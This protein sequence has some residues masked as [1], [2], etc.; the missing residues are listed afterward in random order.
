MSITEIENNIEKQEELAKELYQLTKSRTTKK[1]KKQVEVLKKQI[2]H[3]NNSLPHLINEI[4]ILQE[5]K[6]PKNLVKVSYDRKKKR[7]TVV[8]HKKDHKKY[9]RN[10]K[11]EK[12]LQ[13]KDDNFRKPS[14][15]AKISSK[16][17]FEVSNKISKNKIF[18]KLNLD[19]RKAN[20]RFLLNTYISIMLFFTLISFFAACIL[21]AILLFYKFSVFF[22]FFV[23]TDESILLRAGKSFW[24][25]FVIPITTFLLFYIY[26]GSEAKSIGKKIDQEL[27]FVTI[28]MSA[29]A[30]SN[31]EP[32]SIFQI[33]VKA[34]KEYPYTSSEFKKII[35]YTSIYGYDLVTALKN[36][37]KTTPSDNLKDLLDG[38][39]NAI[40]TGTRITTFLDKRSESLL[41]NYKLE[42]ERYTKVAETFMNIYISAVIAA[43]LVL[44]LTFFL[45]SLGGLGIGLGLNTIS[46]LIVLVVVLINIGFLTFLHFKQPK[47]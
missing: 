38:L 5:K 34:G 7:D 31:I 35:N 45:M 2:R 6:K 40:S 37:S 14:V 3:I 41:F 25:I 8:L 17:F 24:V 1:N 13:K 9:I 20:I 27:P 42:R 18:K 47:Y 29:V 22:P 36:T 16:L 4:S 43:P 12:Q 19:L 46:L 10:I 39:A 28:N 15:I 44:M 33:V 23:N 26:P 11:K 21:F 32:T 30:S